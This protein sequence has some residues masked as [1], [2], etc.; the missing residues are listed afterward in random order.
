MAYL[1][2]LPEVECWPTW[3]RRGNQ[4][5]NV[6]PGS[7]G[8]SSELAAALRDWSDKWDATYDLKDDPANP[9]FLSVDVER[10]FWR[11]GAEMAARLRDELGPDWTIEYDPK[12]SYPSA[13]V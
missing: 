2:I 8:I 6:D 7:L 10:H 9:K 5:D 12:T 3:V 11:E 4:F 13:H 1:R